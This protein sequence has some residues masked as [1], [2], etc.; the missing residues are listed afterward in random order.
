MKRFPKGGVFFCN[1][2]CNLLLEDVLVLGKYFL[3]ENSFL[4]LTVDFCQ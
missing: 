2:C 4:H 3:N 1:K